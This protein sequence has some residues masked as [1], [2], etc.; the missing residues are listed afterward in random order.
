MKKFL[1]FITVL[2]PLASLKLIALAADQGYVLKV[3]LPGIPTQ[4]F[5]TPGQYIGQIYRFSFIAAGLVAIL[6]ITYHAIRYTI[7]AGNTSLQSDARDGITQ[8]LLGLGLLLGAYLILYTINPQLVQLKEPQVQTIANTTH[9]TPDINT[10]SNLNQTVDTLTNYIG[11]GKTPEEQKQREIDVAN[12][13]TKSVSLLSPDQMAVLSTVRDDL[14]SDSSQKDLITR[15]DQKLKLMR[16]L[17]ANNPTT[18]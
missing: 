9:S 12:Y 16:T 5:S 13:L 3:N 17:R 11:Q 14:Y 1:Y 2:V 10:V 7:S 15:I 4:S 18:P 6:I 8:S